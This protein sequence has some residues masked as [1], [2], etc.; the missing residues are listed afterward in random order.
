[1]KI[2]FDA[3]PLF[4]ANKSG[5]SYFTQG[6]IE[7]LTK[8]ANPEDRLIGQYHNFLGRKPTSV[9]PSFSKT[10]YK[11]TTLI[12][13]KAIN[14]ARRAGLQP[15]FEMLL[16]SRADIFLFTNFVAMPVV[17]G[18]KK[19]SVIY[20]MGFLDCPQYVPDRLASY[21]RKWVPYTTKNSDLLVVNSEFTKLQLLTHYQLPERKVIVIPI[22]P[23]PQSKPTAGTLKKFSI[24]KPYIL[25]VG[26]IEPRKNIINLVKA[27]ASLPEKIRSSHSLVLAGGKG[28][29]DAKSLDVI[30]QLQRKG[31]SIILT[32]YVS[33][34]E[35]A[36]LYKDSL[37]CIQPSHYEGFGMPILEAMSFGK[38]VVCS[39]ISVF[40]EVAG[41]AALYC[42]QD[43]S[44]DISLSIEK[45]IIDNKL[46]QNLEKKSSQRIATYPTWDQI[47]T[48]FYNRLKKLA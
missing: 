6:L 16:R 12:P 22:P 20:D 7:A 17:T 42:S 18:G 2:A 29:K 9:L 41:N 37:F 30:Q 48:D 33:D 31:I 5:V 27:F 14:I 32:G 24:T 38:A 43:D 40:K 23:A 10:T 19:V 45:L 1:M 26:T 46:R 4:R 3:N 25:F 34:G 11:E 28:W 39:D 47:G 15:P 8:A 36:A 44:K 13:T 35:K 21:L